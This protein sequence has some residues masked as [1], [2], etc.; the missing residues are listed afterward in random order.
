VENVTIKT[1]N[2]AASGS[3]SS[4]NIF[5]GG[6][7]F[8][9][10]STPA[11]TT[12]TLESDTYLY[13]RDHLN[14][15]NSLSS[16]EGS[17]AHGGVFINMND[18]NSM[19]IT[20]V[21]IK[22]GNGADTIIAHK[23]VS[24]T[25]SSGAGND[26]VY[27]HHSTKS[28]TIN[29]GDGNDEIYIS[30]R[31]S[32]TADTVTTGSG[33]DTVVVSY[34]YVPQSAQFTPKTIITDFTPGSGGDKI[35]F[36][37]TLDT[38][39]GLPSDYVTEDYSSG[40]TAKVG[41]TIL[42]GFSQVAAGATVPTGTGMMVLDDNIDMSGVSSDTSLKNAL[43]ELLTTTTANTFS[44][45]S[46]EVNPLDTTLYLAVDDGVDAYVFFL[47]LKGGQSNFDSGDSSKMVVKLTGVSDVTT[48][49]AEN[50][51]DFS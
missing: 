5:S 31:T 28:N 25:I 22:T 9:N 40:P 3:P 18:S 15:S 39:S 49:T 42:S 7:D 47:T 27:I 13:F 24:N 38:S 43:I 11:M 35:D 46:T 4:S 33:S 50:F 29:L 12:L 32:G 10:W 34:A 30:G 21:D 17:A 2:L 51:I 8:F 41:G 45:I 48:L 14:T 1:A 36:Y 16:I 6:V 26:K 19:S 44:D 37:E 23:G 20:S